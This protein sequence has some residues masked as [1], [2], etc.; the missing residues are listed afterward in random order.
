[1]NN[2]EKHIDLLNEFKKLNIL[3][4]PSTRTFMQ[5]SGYPHFEN[6]CSNILSFF[7]T[8]D[9][10]HGFKE[11]FFRSL[12]EAAG[13]NGLQLDNV[14]A[15]REVYTDNNKRL[16]IL[17]TND[18]VIVGIENKIFSGVQNNLEE[19]EE[20]IKKEAKAK[21]QKN[22]NIILSLRDESKIATNYKYINVTYDT[23][24]DRVKKNMGE[25]IEEANNSWIIYLKDFMKTILNLKGG[26]D[27]MNEDMLNFI[28]K[29][30][31]DLGSL[32]WECNEIKK[33]L[34]IKTK[35]LSQF[36]DLDK[37]ENEFKLS[38]WL[39]NPKVY[40]TSSFVIDLQEKND[41]VSTVEAKLNA[42]GWQIGYFNRKG[43]VDIRKRIEAK[44]KELGISYSYFN[45]EENSESKFVV[46]K[47]YKHNESYEV[48]QEGVYY[49]MDKL[50]LVIE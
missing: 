33:I 21:G 16:D 8:T 18:T 49:A 14:T 48:I 36:I 23:L 29:N 45:K 20:R 28:H 9:E 41:L 3:K 40:V 5:V 30:S 50:K 15:E 34:T 44:L 11:L 1:M 31:K 46:L 43:G 35:E 32:L 4:K 13:F 12:L 26:V 42:C 10:E 47:D 24:F 17:L 6:V 7:F 38:T 39:Y 27:G 37:Y 25:Y 2:L 22:I 19:Y